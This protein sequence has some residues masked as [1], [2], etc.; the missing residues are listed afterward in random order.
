MNPLFL[1][2]AAMPALVD[3]RGPRFELDAWAQWPAAALLDASGTLRG[4][5]HPSE[6]GYPR[7][8]VF[9]EQIAA[10]DTRIQTAIEGTRPDPQPPSGDRA[11]QE[12][13]DVPSAPDG[14]C[15][16]AS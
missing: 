16:P 15:V 3:T 11:V 7:L 1:L 9:D 12:R 8:D 10:F 6:A 14:A 5:L 13:A 2:L 4:V